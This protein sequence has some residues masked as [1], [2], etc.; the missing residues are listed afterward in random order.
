MA[1]LIGMTATPEDSGEYC[2]TFCRYCWPMY[3]VPMSV[4][5][6]M[7]PATAATQNS[8]RLAT[9]RSYRGF[10]ARRCWRTN[11]TPATTVIPAKIRARTP[12]LG[13]GAK[14]I[15]STSPAMSTMDS[16]PPS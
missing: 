13:I 1:R 3:M 10:T 2:S 5:N 6:T 9:S 7:I 15:V 8:R 4:P 16:M 14:L 12:P 11:S